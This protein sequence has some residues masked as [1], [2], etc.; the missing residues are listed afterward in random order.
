MAS[1]FGFGGGS[2]SA[3]KPTEKDENSIE[4]QRGNLNKVLSASSKSERSLVG[5][6]MRPGQRRGSPRNMTGKI[7]SIGSASITKE[8]KPTVFFPQEITSGVAL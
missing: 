3:Q 2:Q 1:F 4:G 8:S 6:P 5:P 7:P